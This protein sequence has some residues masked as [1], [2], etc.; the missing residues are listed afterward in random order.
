MGQHLRIVPNQYILAMDDADLIHRRW[1]DGGFDNVCGRG[2]PKFILTGHSKGGGQA[3]FAGFHFW[4]DAIVFNSDLPDPYIFS[5][6][7][8]ME[9]APILLQWVQGAGRTIQSVINC[10]SPSPVDPQL[11]FY[12]SDKVI[13]VR[14]VNDKIVKNLLPYC[15]L[16]HAPFEWLSDTSICSANDGHGINTVIRELKTCALDNHTRFHEAF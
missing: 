2:H 14:M 3:Q 9:E 12:Q 6:W 7:A 11:V 15:N 8:T 10:A 13:D 16:P 4:L 5:E 1:V